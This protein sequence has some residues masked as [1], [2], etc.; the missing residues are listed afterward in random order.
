M[1]GTKGQKGLSFVIGCRVLGLRDIGMCISPFNAFLIS[2]GMETLPLRI[3]KS[4]DNALA[5]AKFLEGHDRIKWVRYGGLASSSN[6][7]LAQLYT[8]KGTGS[9][10]TFGLKG[11]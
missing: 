1:M 7:A 6:H 3:Q 2:M 5:V 8:P 10:F 11:G 4:S 9:L